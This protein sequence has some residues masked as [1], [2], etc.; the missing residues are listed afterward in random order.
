V[1]RAKADGRWGA[2]YDPPSTA[3]IPADFLAAL[4]EHPK[5]KAFFATLN[6]TN[7]FAVSH[8]LQTAVKPETRARRLAKM[9]EQLDRE[10][11]FH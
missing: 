5:A 1:E 10:E 2:A 11:K 6:K 4:E 8:R 7:R 3:E 9:I